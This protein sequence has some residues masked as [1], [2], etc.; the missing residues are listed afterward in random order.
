M[1]GLSAR[2]KEYFGLRGL[3]LEDLEA[4]DREDDAD[5]AGAHI[6][7]EAADEVG[8]DEHQD[9]A[10]DAAPEAVALDAL[11][12]EALEAV[13]EDDEQERHDE[14]ADH[15]VDAGC[16][17]VQVGVGDAGGDEVRAAGHGGQTGAA[18]G[19][20]HAVGHQRRD[21]GH[22]GIKA[23][24]DEEGGGD[25]GGGAGAGSALHED[26]DE[27]ADDDQLD[28]AVTAGDGGELRLDDVHR[29]ERGLDAAPGLRPDGAGQVDGGVLH[30]RKERV[31]QQNGQQERK[32]RNLEGRK[33]EADHADQNEQDRH[34]REEERDDLDQ[35]AVLVKVRT[36][37]SAQHEGERNDENE[38]RNKHEPHIIAARALLVCQI[39]FCHVLTLSLLFD[40]QGF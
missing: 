35:A 6:G 18:E 37:D 12:L 34:K 40:I 24:A 33:I 1:Y 31:A 38:Q 10:D 9:R 28:A 3:D 13:G 30:V 22:D 15:V 21:D 39:F 29:E 8:E 26:G 20:A 11:A 17:E 5:E 23:Q 19:G 16:G 27:Q 7:D 14:D 4:E 36:V 25:G 32:R 2:T